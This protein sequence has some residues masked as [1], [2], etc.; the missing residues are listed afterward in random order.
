MSVKSLNHALLGS[1]F[2]MIEL[3]EFLIKSV[4]P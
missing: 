2:R 4:L 3:S 1:T